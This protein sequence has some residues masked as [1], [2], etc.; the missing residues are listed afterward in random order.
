MVVEGILESR[1]IMVADMLMH[2][3][4]PD[5]GRTISAMILL[6]GVVFSPR[7]LI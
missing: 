2:V 4:A 5:I 7:R 3:K 6:P 1:V